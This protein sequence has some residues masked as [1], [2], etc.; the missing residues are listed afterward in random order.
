[1]PRDLASRLRARGPQRTW[2]R[3]SYSAVIGP[4]WSPGHVTKMRP[5]EALAIPARCARS[6]VKASCAPARKGSGSRV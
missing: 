2:P 3:G 5:L 1:M 6:V 4:K